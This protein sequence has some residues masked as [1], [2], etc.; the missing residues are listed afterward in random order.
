MAGGL[1]DFSTRSDSRVYNTTTTNTDSFNR[2]QSNSQV[3]DNVGN[4]TLQLAGA[5]STLDKILPFVA[6][7]AIAL[8]VF[9]SKK[10]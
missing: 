5:N 3:L 8:A 9:A 1:F 6:I 4:V 2:S 7:G 10:N